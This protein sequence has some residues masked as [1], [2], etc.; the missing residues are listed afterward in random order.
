MLDCIVR[1][2]VKNKAAKQA[3]KKR[4]ANGNNIQKNITDAKLVSAGVLA[5]NGVFA[6]NNN[7]FIAGLKAHQNK[8]KN[9]S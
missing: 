7:E 6:L 3:A 2:R 8:E 5:K 9:S 4:L 1:G